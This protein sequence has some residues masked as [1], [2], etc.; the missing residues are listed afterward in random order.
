M[1]IVI[2][3]D[4]HI[5]SPEANVTKLNYFLST[6]ECDKLILAGDMFDLWDSSSE[7]I[8]LKH[9]DTLKILKEIITRGIKV[10]Y[11]LGNHDEDYV[12]YP[13]IELQIVPT[14][15][16][17]LPNGKHVKV[18]HGHE[19]DFIYKHHYH[20][21]KTSAWV[22]KI[23]A[24]FIGVSF[25]SLSGKMTCT[26]LKNNDYSRT[27]EKIHANARNELNKKADVLIMGHTHAP[28]H[29]FNDDLIEFWNSGDWKVH[30]SYI[31][32]ED[33]AINLYFYH[34]NL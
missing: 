22:N 31:V 5:G 2:L 4:C 12:K 20:L 25:K 23:M 32:I 29:K 28:E 21:Y 27:V 18:I 33:N 9:Q 15:D 3:S 17:L 34:D 19:F 1:K 11:L 14:I 8:K 10:E 30:N 24:K 13:V 6:I 26:N 7:N 16:F